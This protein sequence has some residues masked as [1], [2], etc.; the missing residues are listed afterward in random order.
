MLDCDV[1]CDL[2]VVYRSGEASEETRRLVEEHLA[3]CTSCRKAFGQGARVEEALDD[4]EPAGPPTNGRRFIART[5]RL[6]FGVI[7]GILFV[8]GYMFAASQRFLVDHFFAAD[9][10]LAPRAVESSLILAVAMAALYVF[11]IFW[12]SRRKTTRRGVEIALSAAVAVPLMV[13]M[14]IAFDF[15]GIVALPAGVPVMALAL[16]ALV[17]TFIL[18]PRLPYATIVTV[19][20]LVIAFVSV[21]GRMTGAIMMPQGFVLPDLVPIGRPVPE[22]PP[23]EAVEVDLSALGLSFKGSGAVQSVGGVDLGGEVDAVRATYGGDGHEVFLTAARFAD[24]EGAMHFYAR[25]QGSTPNRMFT[26]ISLT[27]MKKAAGLGAGSRMFNFRDGRAYESWQGGNWVIVVE[28]PGPMLEAQ[29]LA[30]LVASHVAASYQARDAGSQRG[31]T[32]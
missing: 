23:E 31:V 12:R 13:L 30:Q 25:W 10:S 6:I 16:A 26:P 14:F 32:E 1:I 15:A 2:M 28:V 18:L 11:L 29:N 22:A 24:P 20:V 27:L 3:Q 19:V 9:V 7:V 5:R 4:L 8:T 17:V 21:S